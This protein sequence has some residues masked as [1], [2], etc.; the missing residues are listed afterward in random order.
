M[1]ISGWKMS[2]HS[3]WQAVVESGI[4]LI[5]TEPLLHQNILTNYLQGQRRQKK[6]NMV[7]KLK[8]WPSFMCPQ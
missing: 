4:P 3:I 6:R 5:V 8:V 7:E 2:F 1:N